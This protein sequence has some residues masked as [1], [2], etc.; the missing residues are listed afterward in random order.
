MKL[1]IKAAVFFL[2]NR[3]MESVLKLPIFKNMTVS[4]E[5]KAEQTVHLYRCLDKLSTEKQKII[6]GIF[7]EEKAEKQLAQQLQ[8]SASTIGY[9]KRKILKA[10][11]QEMRGYIESKSFYSCYQCLTKFNFTWKHCTKGYSV[12]YHTTLH[13]VLYQLCMGKQKI[14]KRNQLVI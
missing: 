14:K 6:H 12:C 8:M 1:K 9:R 4:V 2:K 3:I 11:C 5:V 13:N 10:L 7:F